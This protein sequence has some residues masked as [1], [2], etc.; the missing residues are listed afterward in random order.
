MSI[1]QTILIMLFT[2]CI[3]LLFTFTFHSLK[4]TL[5]WGVDK[6]KFQREYA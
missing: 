5:D 6:K 4:N 2:A 3:T 1:A